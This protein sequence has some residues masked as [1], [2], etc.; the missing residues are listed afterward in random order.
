MKK[1]LFASMILTKTGPI[2]GWLN[3]KGLSCRRAA[4][5]R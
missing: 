1:I 3:F 2:A 4:A 5:K